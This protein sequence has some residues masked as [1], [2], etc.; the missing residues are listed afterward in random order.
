MHSTYI[1]LIPLARACTYDKESRVLEYR[2]SRDP[3]ILAK[4]FVSNYGL[5]TREANKFYG[6]ASEDIASFSMEELHNALTSFDTRH[7]STSSF[8]TYF[9]TC[10]RNRLRAETQALNYDKRKAMRD[11][12]EYND[13][14]LKPLC[15]EVACEL[16]AVLEDESMFTVRERAYCHYVMSDTVHTKDI[17]FAIKEDISSAAVHYIKQSLKNKL[18]YLICT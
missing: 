5:I 16:S 1:N 3:L 9:C 6:L 4:L 13:D 14:T 7:I 12:Y 2:E 8:M 18:N 10:F 17:D 11:Y 15:Q